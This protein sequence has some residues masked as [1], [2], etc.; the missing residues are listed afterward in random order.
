MRIRRGR[1]HGQAVF[2]FIIG[3]EIS[4]GLDRASR[5]AVT[6][7]SLFDNN[8]GSVEYFVDPVRGE[9]ILVNNIAAGI[10]M[11]EGSAWL[12]RGFRIDDRRQ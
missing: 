5:D 9:M 1:P 4:A 8:I 11:D 7:N 10:F 3:C 12:H 6:A 2:F